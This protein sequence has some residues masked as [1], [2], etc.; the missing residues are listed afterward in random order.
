MLEYLSLLEGNVARKPW[1]GNTVSG[2]TSF[3][4]LTYVREQGMERGFDGEC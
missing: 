3:K 4:E 1:N 2:Y